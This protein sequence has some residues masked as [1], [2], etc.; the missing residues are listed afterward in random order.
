MIILDLEWNRGYDKKRLEEVLQIGA[1]KIDR[2]GG[3]I[4]DTFN[5]YIRPSVHKRFDHGARAL[6]ELDL[7][8]NSDILFPEAL[9]AFRIWVGEEKTFAVWGGKGDFDVLTKNCAHW[10][11]TPITPETLYDFQMAF[12]FIAGAEGRQVALWRAVEYCN[13]PDIFTFHNALYDALYTALLSKWLTPGSLAFTPPKSAKRRKTKFAELTFQ[14]PPRRR[15]GPFPSVEAALNGRAVRRAACPV[16]G[17]KDWATQWISRSRQ[18]SATCHCPEH[19][20][21]LTRLTLSPQE[22]GTWQGRLAVPELTPALRQEFEN[23]VK[24]GQRYPCKG[25]GKRKRRRRRTAIKNV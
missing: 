3:V 16:C 5:I 7:S 4:T 19:G 9:E 22:N 6:P 2:L 24:K 1:V 23:V 18:Y 21:F 20:H 15:V 10:G 17:A 8:R 25:S 14:A 11:L 12:S 13:I